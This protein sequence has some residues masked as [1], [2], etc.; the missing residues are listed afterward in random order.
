MATFRRGRHEHVEKNPIRIPNKIYPL[1]KI[2]PFRTRRGET[3]P[4]ESEFDVEMLQFEI[5]TK[6]TL[7]TQ[8]T[9]FRIRRGETDPAESEFDVQTL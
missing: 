9:L 7:S 5:R 4:A 2:H 3:E 6:P 1:G 8:F